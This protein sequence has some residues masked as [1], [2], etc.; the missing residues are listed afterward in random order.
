MT[1]T[2]LSRRM[3]ITTASVTEIKKGK[4]RP[5]ERWL[6]IAE[7]T[8]VPATW[9]I[10]G[11]GHPPWSA[12]DQGPAYDAP[13]AWAAALFDEIKAVRADLASLR[14]DCCRADDDTEHRIRRD[15]AD[16]PLR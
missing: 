14:E 10:D 1:A 16:I 4:S 12:R 9:L 7:I 5:N 13:P 11:T 8:G 6:E 3:G 2:A 15:S